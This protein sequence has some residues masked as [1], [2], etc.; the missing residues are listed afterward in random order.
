MADP[1]DPGMPLLHG[2]TLTLA[3]RAWER[4]TTASVSDDVVVVPLGTVAADRPLEIRCPLGD[5]IGHWTPDAALGRGLRPDWAP[6]VQVRP[7]GGAAIGCLFD[8]RSQNLLTWALGADTGAVQVSAGVV[9]ET[10][11]FLAV[12]RPDRPSEL[13]LRIDRRTVP[14]AEAL[15]AAATWWQEDGCILEVPDACFEPVYSTWYGFHQDLDPV[16]LVE[17]AGMAARLGFRT[18]IIDDGWQ[19]TDVHRGYAYVGDW[20]PAPAKVGDLSTLVER[21][22]DA[23]LR[24]LL[25]VA[26]ALLGRESRAAQRFSHL[27]VSTDDHLGMTVLDAR[28]PGVRAEMI[29]R[30]ERL[31]T[32]HGLDGLKVDFVDA[33]SRSAPPP[34]DGADSDHL[35][36]AV[37]LLL[38]G[39]TAAAATNGVPMIEYR[40]SYVGPRMWRHANMF[41]AFDCPLDRGANRVRTVD[42]RLMLPG[43]AVHSDPLTWDPAATPETVAEH[44]A[45]ALFAVPQVSVRLANLPD[46]HREVIAAWLGFC[47]A[48]RDLLYRAPLCAER[49]DL[50]YT[51]VEATDGD[52]TVVALFAPQILT[53]ALP[54]ILYAVNATGAPG[55]TVRSAPDVTVEVVEVRDCRGRPLTPGVQPHPDAIT[56]IVVPRG[57]IAQLQ[58]RASGSSPPG[59]P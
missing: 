28:H 31:V 45:S 52:E 2:L 8:Q 6:A 38:A 10:A 48:R 49:P 39:L 55:L 21:V 56:D 53:A 51:R 33:W 44:F 20:V 22:H 41:R 54:G 24:C 40:Q 27:V 58:V 26:P 1:S 37:E 34:A 43:R 42:L 5:A 57:G 36:D 30:C 19:T 12:L 9:E 47:A 17:E 16:G 13:R 46:D 4:T 50:G 11:E 23:G 15:R 59:H 25:W 29:D 32:D 35:D 3:G 14:M 7:V 18:L